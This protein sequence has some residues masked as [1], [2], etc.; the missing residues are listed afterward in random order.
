MSG[1]RK[2]H[3]L[4]GILMG[5][6]GLLCALLL[7]ALFYGMMVYQLAGIDGGT[8][9]GALA[10]E[11]TPAPLEE[12]APVQALFPG[13]LL[14]LDPSM[15]QQTGITAQDVTVS[16]QVCRVITI[17]YAL[18]GGGTARTISATPEA[19]LERLSDSGVQMQLM[20]GFVLAGLDALYAVQGEARL[21]AVRYGGCVYI[22]EAEAD[23][24]TLYELGAA[25]ALVRME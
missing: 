2:K 20:T 16:G 9:D 15:A 24:Q 3:A 12:G 6:V 7:G 10:A 8:E 4:T 23:E 11:G 18:E 22:L 19:Y 25:S 21:L 14:A 17:S 1:R 5:L 13:V